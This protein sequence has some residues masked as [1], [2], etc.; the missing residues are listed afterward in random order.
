MNPTSHPAMRGEAVIGRKPPGV[1]R[2]G[3]RSAT[4]RPGGFRPKG[5]LDGERGGAPTD[6]GLISPG[7]TDDSYFSSNGSLAQDADV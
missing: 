6:F 3:A 5:C 2:A 1:E 7:S 4:T